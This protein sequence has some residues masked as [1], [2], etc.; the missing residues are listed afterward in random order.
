MFCDE[1]IRLES[2]TLDDKYDF[3][4]T[5][6]QFQGMGIIP[7]TKTLICVSSVELKGSAIVAPM[8]GDALTDLVTQGGLLVCERCMMP[9]ILTG[10]IL[11][12]GV[13]CVRWA[14]TG[15]G[16]GGQTV[17]GCDSQAPWEEAALRLSGGHVFLE[18]QR[19]SSPHE[20]LGCWLMNGVCDLHNNKGDRRKH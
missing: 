18:K 17:A 20:V 11:F 7:F 13:Y 6:L 10:N 19:V 16:R 3:L 5:Q 14:Q 15:S 4:K 8:L 12:A 9:L 1:I 2:L